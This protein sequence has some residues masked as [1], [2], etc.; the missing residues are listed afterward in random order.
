MRKISVITAKRK[1]L[2]YS[3]GEEYPYDVDSDNFCFI[4]DGWLTQSN[5]KPWVTEGKRNN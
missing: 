5:G 3:R 4:I 1:A 2:Y